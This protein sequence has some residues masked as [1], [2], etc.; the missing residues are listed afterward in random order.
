[1]NAPSASMQDLAHRLVA[2][3]ATNQTASGSDMHEVARVSEKLRVS[4]TRFAGA[5]GF[6]ALLRRALALARGDV[7][8]L[9]AVTVKAD[10]RIEGFVEFAAQ[11]SNRETDGGISI[12]ARL[13][14]LLVTF[15]GESLTLQ[16][17]REAWP[18][19]SPEEWHSRSKTL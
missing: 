3:E 7:P 17:V 16:L 19:L 14:E 2:L 6:T 1:M 8:S 5:D 18:D 11:T 15:V 13:L 12:I 9:Q 4:L 10:G